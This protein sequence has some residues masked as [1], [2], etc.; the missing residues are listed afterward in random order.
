MSYI[1][2]RYQDW[3]K[4][5]RDI[6]EWLGVPPWVVVVSGAI[7]SMAALIRSI[8]IF[9]LEDRLITSLTSIKE[10]T[11]EGTDLYDHPAWSI[12][13]FSL[14]LNV[15]TL[16]ITYRLYR[17]L[18]HRPVM[19]LMNKVRDWLASAAA[20]IKDYLEQHAAAFAALKLLIL[21]YVV[22]SAGLCIWWVHNVF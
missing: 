13:L 17:W 21:L 14:V 5:V 16:Y 12:I 9:G 7:M 2:G 3:L 18:F 15:I 11:T 1:S 10:S 8:V 4:K 22:A 6:S 20:R 19:W